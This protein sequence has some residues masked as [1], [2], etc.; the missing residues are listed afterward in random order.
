MIGLRQASKIDKL[1]D[2]QKFPRGFGSPYRNIFCR[3][4]SSQEEIQKSD[5][6]LTRGCCALVVSRKDSVLA[7]KIE[8]KKSSMFFVIWTTV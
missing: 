2:C 1:L 6:I 5:A 3:A 7:M 4:A 8:T